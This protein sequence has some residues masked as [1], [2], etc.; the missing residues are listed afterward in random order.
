M[1]NW[2]MS[3]Y[4]TIK[5][6]ERTS[7]QLRFETY[8]T[9]NHTQFSNVSRQ[10]R[11]QSATDWTQMDPLFLQPTAARAPRTMQVALRLNF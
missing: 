3:L 4:R 10:A 7:M 9:P 5:L 8:N 1:H 6:R 2:D 11:F